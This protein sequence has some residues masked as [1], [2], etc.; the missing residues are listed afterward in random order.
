M[1]VFSSICFFVDFLI[2]LCFV[3]SQHLLFVPKAFGPAALWVCAL[4][5]EKSRAIADLARLPLAWWSSD[6]PLRS[7]EDVVTKFQIVPGF[8]MA[9]DEEGPVET[10]EPLNKR[11][12][13]HHVVGGNAMDWFMSLRSVHPCWSS[14]ACLRFAQRFSSEM[15]AP[16]CVDSVSKWSRS[17]QPS[18]WYR[19][20]VVQSTHRVCTDPEAC[21]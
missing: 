9:D 4:Y 18:R 2:I 20:E 15:F 14:A 5:R 6:R 12:R 17:G 7:T 3:F 16:V 8:P 13:Q 21:F 11:R 10:A 1:L 19:F